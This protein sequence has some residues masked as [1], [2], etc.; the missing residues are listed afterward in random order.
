MPRR[1]PPPWTVTRTPG[2]W[3]VNDA[4][5]FAVAYTY[6]DDTP[7]GASANKMTVDE[8]RRLAVN[9]AKLPELLKAQRA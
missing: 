6:G 8:A 4:N 3:C 2:G 1:F 9:I 5:G 7:Q